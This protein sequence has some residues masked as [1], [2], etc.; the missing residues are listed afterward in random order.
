MKRDF[1]VENA[2]GEIY[3][4]TF[5]DED[6]REFV[7]IANKTKNEKSGKVLAAENPV[8]MFNQVD[9]DRESVQAVNLNYKLG[10]DLSSN[11]S[12]YFSGKIFGNI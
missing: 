2:F 4:K 8:R 5:L 6:I 3:E 12:N 1:F 9:V 11:F 10:G 7:E